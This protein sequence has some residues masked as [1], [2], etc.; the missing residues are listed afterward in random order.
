MVAAQGDLEA[1]PLAA[2][3][4]TEPKPPEPA[5]ADG[6]AA[7]EAFWQVRAVL[8]RDI[9]RAAA[10]HQVARGQWPAPPSAQAPPGAATAPHRPRV[11]EGGVVLLPGHRGHRG[12]RGCSTAS[13]SPAPGWTC[14][15]RRRTASPS[16][17]S[18][19]R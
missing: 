19:A 9:A 3:G 10:G 7:G 16:P 4:T 5:V 12:N 1:P 14:G 18:G 6:Q 11:A 15:G 2:G 13:R 8:A 17:P